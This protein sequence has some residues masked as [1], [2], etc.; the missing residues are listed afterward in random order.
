[1]VDYTV[2]ASYID[3]PKK[4]QV[5]RLDT[6]IIYHNVHNS[7]EH[8]WKGEEPS[9]HPENLSY[10]IWLI[11][12]IGVTQTH[13]VNPPDHDMVLAQNDIMI[14]GQYKSVPVLANVAS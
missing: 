13:R 10:S 12:S 6:H 14:L 7:T 9:R 5:S 11:G 2:Y 4:P 8:K 1:M 3:Q